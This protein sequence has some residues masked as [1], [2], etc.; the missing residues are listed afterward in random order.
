MALTCIYVNFNTRVCKCDIAG[1]KGCAYLERRF[2]GHILQGETLEEASCLRVTILQHR[3][4]ALC[5]S[6]IA[7]IPIGPHETIGFFFRRFSH[8]STV[9]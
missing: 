6:C 3:Q 5:R 1:I 9:A 4:E 7:L 8:G 2:I